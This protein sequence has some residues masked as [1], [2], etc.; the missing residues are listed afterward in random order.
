M[1]RR[2]KEG[3]EYHFQLV[4]T[5]GGHTVLGGDREF[6]TTGHHRVP[7]PAKHRNS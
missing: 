7:A 5:S 6:R 2:L 1:K 4:C 3:T